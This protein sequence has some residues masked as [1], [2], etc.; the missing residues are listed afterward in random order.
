MRR[1]SQEG[2]T[3]IELLITLFIAVA[4]LVS[5]WQ[6]YSLI[7]RD[8]GNSRMQ[9]RASNV[10]YEY[11]RKYSSTAQTPC[12]QQ[13]PLTASPIT[14]DGLGNATVSV[15]VTCPNA[16]TSAIS[17]VT[18]TV[19]YSAA[20]G[21]ET[22][23]ESTFINATSGKTLESGLVGWWPLNQSTADATAGGNTGTK[24][25]SGVS[26]ATGQKGFA[27]SAFAFN[28]TSGAITL[29]DTTAL[30][31]GTGAGQSMTISLWYNA[32]GSSTAFQSIFSRRD[33]S[34]AN[35]DYSIFTETNTLK[36]GIGT[37]G[38]SCAWAGASAT[39]PSR[40][41]WHHVVGIVNQTGT[42][43]GVKNLW[44][45]GVKIGSCNYAQKGVSTTPARIGAANSS[46]GAYFQGSVDDL[47]FYNR[48]LVESE[49]VSLY[50]LGAH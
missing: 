4:F 12:K 45:D 37:S 36:F 24:T 21:T 32:S 15:A 40:G 16:N 39:E 14:V 6:L 5:G 23:S 30:N 43:S 49:I 18:V 31:F 9:A 2:F 17:K 19:S 42:T 8:G 29:T 48:A 27:T 38:D 44:I 41:S 25:A 10:A 20:S 47:R 46:I 26:D 35:T 22:V 11:I 13:S 3:V 28:G 33:S 1:A 34:S 7:I 50:G